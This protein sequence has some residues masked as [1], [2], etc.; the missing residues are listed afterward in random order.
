MSELIN[1]AEIKFTAIQIGI[2]INDVMEMK[3]SD[4]YQMVD[5]YARMNKG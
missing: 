1:W 3:P 2:Q 4:F 5:M